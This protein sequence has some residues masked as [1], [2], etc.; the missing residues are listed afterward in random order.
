[1]ISAV[2]LSM[3]AAALPPLEDST[4]RPLRHSALPPLRHSAP[5]PLAGA[6]PYESILTEFTWTFHDFSRLPRKAYSDTFNIGGCQWYFVIHIFF[7][8]LNL[9][10]NVVSFW[11]NCYLTLFVSC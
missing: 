10:S 4:L 6:S 8:W 3:H 9:H 5:P 2:P 11:V 1:M 7:V